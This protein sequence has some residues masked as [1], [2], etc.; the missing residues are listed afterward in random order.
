MADDTLLLLQLQQDQ[1]RLKASRQEP[2]TEAGGIQ[3]GL[4][5]GARDVAQGAAGLVG[6]AYDP[7]ASGINAVLGTDIE[8]LR[9]NVRRRLTEA[10]V[11]EPETATERV[12]SSINEAATGA[13]SG[14]GVAGGVARTATG[15]VAR[16]VGGQMAAAPLAQ[17]VGGAGAGAGQQLA[18][19]AGAGPVG[20]AAAALGGGILAGGAAATRLAAPVADD[21]SQVGA[22]RGV[23][24]MTSDVSPPETFAGKWLQGVGEKI[25]VTGTGG[26]RSAQAGERVKAVQ[27]IV[28]QYSD[29]ATSLTDDVLAGV[30]D[31]LLRGRKSSL[32]KYAQS[33]KQ[34]IDGLSQAGE[35]PVAQTVQKIDDEIARLEALGVADLQPIVTR[36]KDWRSAIE[37]KNLSQLEEIRVQLGE[38]FSAPELS[39]IRSA[40]EK[41]LA[42]IYGPLRDDMG[43]FIKANGA[44]RDFTK[45]STANKRLSEMAGEL[46]V[47]SLKSVLKNGEATP[48]SV[49]KLLFSQDASS[50][51]RLYNQLSPDGRANA[52]AAILHDVLEKSGGLE[53][54]SPRKFASNLDRRAKQVG[55]FFTGSDRRAMEGFSKL[56]KATQRAD[57]AAL[58]PPTGVQALPVVGGAVATD[59][60]G[61]AGAGLLSVA[62]IGGM[63]RMYESKAMRPILLGLSRVKPGSAEEAALINRGLAVMR[64][65]NQQ[66]GASQ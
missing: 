44:R 27:D 62:T 9:E 34:V 11:P 38:S 22:Q 33:K 18:A 39:N 28:R 41:V 56:L 37:G 3:R 12:I 43:E 35:V 23:R 55:I 59:V 8:P 36:L 25:P 54:V 66:Q 45:W 31:D 2:D 49:K 6:L 26:L 15:P 14:A 63:A 21:I 13:L 20:Q 4:A 51:R 5:L 29:D 52:R 10:G 19:E 30:T 46:G 61:G 16:A 50:I 65:A 40:G 32:T 17:T 1:A 24:V 42:S 53:N 47:A 57:E 58:A 64:E 48:E 60:L 7:I